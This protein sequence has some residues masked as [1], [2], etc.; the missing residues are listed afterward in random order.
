MA[1]AGGRVTVRYS[2][3]TDILLPHSTQKL[4]FEGFLHTSP[5]PHNPGAIK[6]VYF[7][8]FGPVAGTQ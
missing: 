2:G 7:F 6:H 8:A 1:R 4:A 3:P 5:Q